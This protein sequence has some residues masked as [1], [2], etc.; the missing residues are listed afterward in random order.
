MLK[1][2]F[3]EP[4]RKQYMDGR[5]NLCKY[6]CTIFDNSNKRIV[7]E[8]AVTG[9]AKCAPGDTLNPEFGRSL[10]DS[11]AKLQGYRTAAKIL[12]KDEIDDMMAIMEQHVTLL[13]FIDYMR[14]LKKKELTHIEEICSE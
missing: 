11:R 4:L 13:E 10:A 3:S 9:T 14:Y 1:L 6:K 2:R 8:F 5:I 7:H 12:S